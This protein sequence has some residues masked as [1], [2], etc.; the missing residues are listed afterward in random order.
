LSSEL[1][2]D[3]NWPNVDYSPDQTFEILINDESVST[4]SL[5]EDFYP[6]V[7]PPKEIAD[8]EDFKPESWV[9]LAEIDDETA[10]KPED[11]DEDAPLMIVD[12]SATK[13]EDWL[14][15]EPETIPD[16]EAEKPEEWD[17]EEDGD[18]IPPS[19]PN[20]KCE[21]AAGC[22]PWTQPKIKNP[23][24]KVSRLS[25]FHVDNLTF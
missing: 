15:N 18:W 24:F 3:C 22:G 12:N 7:N 25:E 6:A 8:P 1:R 19:V 13:P 4:G 10:T 2:L 21:D 23:D 17:D 9:D 16:P 20:P 14:E 11:W 5:L